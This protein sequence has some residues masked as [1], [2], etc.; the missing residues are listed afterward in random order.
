MYAVVGEAG[1]VLRRG[2]ELPA[3]LRHFD[4]KLIRPID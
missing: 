3:V 2:H 1:Q 4:R